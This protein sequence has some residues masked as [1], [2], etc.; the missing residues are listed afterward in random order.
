VRRSITEIINSILKAPARL[1]QNRF[2]KKI[3]RE[4]R[5]WPVYRTEPTD[6]FIVGY[7]KSGNTWMQNLIAG[8]V[9]GLDPEYLPDSVVSDLI[10]DVYSCRYY[11][12][13]NTP[14]YFKTH[15]LPR[16][17][18]RR[19]IYL[20]RDGR[21]VMVSYYHHLRAIG[22]ADID[23]ADVVTTGKYFTP[24]KWHDHVDA[25]RS[26]PFGAEIVTVRYEDLLENPVEEL[27]RICEFAGIERSDELLEAVSSKASFQKMREK[28]K[29][30]GWANSSWPNSHSF[31]RRG[32]TGSFKD[33]MP[34]NVLASFLAQAGETLR[35]CDYK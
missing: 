3:H 30:S 4:T 12:R 9:Y 26:N 15:D 24:S 35:S 18:Y 28:E 31:V 19:A 29:R 21:D 16:P 17:G 32:E 33:E 5:L 34:A 11:R 27:R 14:M 6:I 23:F 7:P 8:V 25:W 22:I 10:P 13:Y 20:L 1:L 2:D